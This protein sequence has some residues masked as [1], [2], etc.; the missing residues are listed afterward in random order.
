MKR[1]LA[2]RI[3]SKLVNKI[4]RHIE[5]F[6]INPPYDYVQTI[7]EQSIHLYLNLR[8][9]EIKKWVIV[10][11]Y[12]GNEVTTILRNY[13]KCEVVVFECS[14]RYIKALRKK[15]ARNSRVTVINKAVSDVEGTLSFYETNLKGS[16][17]LLEV[18]ELAEKSY[19]MKSA[20]KFSVE[21]TTLD[22]LF[23]DVDIDVLQI[24]VQG[25][26][27]KVLKGAQR[28]L[29]NTKSV[30]S[31][32]S[33]YNE[34]Y[35]GSVNMKDLK[36]ELSRKGFELALLGTD[37]NL[38]GNALFIKPSKIIKQGENFVQV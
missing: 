6:K 30:F 29:E 19:K 18:G 32:V 14:E 22:S 28:V 3:Y 9:E 8:K 5:L 33:I 15:F 23:T 35:K 37:V 26:E 27:L 25:A 13:P 36:D 2:I 24:D 10:G 38:T 1:N 7:N 21:S 16:G 20:E 4:F 11:G 17:S 31:E 34:L 12:L